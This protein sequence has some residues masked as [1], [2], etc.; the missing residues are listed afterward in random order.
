MKAFLPINLACAALAAA[1]LFTGCSKKPAGDV[2]ARV[3]DREITVA[4]FKVEYERRQANRQPLPDRQT[5][6]DQMIDRETLLQQ[7]RVAGLDKATDVRHAYEELLLAKYK[8]TQL[9]PKVSAVKVS[10]DEIQAAYDKDLAQFTQPA[11]AKLAFVFIPVSTR[12]DTN[13]VA[14]AGARANEARQFA[15][16]LPAGARGFGQVAADYSDDQVTR[17]RGGDAGWFATDSIDDRW[18]AEVVAAGFALKNSG[19]MSDVLHAKD[20]FYLVKKLDARAA[21][22]TPLEQVRPQ[23]ERRLLLAKHLETERQFQTQSRSATQVSTDATLL[24]AT[25]YPNPTLGKTAQA[26]MPAVVSTP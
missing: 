1:A 24:A 6:L 8:E 20:G 22:V 12:A 14:E 23:I 9:D 5:L 11:K 25:A 13:K 18:P 10:A 16:A 15:A 19:D 3:G 21:A 7:A 26:R 4:D 2:L 17:Y